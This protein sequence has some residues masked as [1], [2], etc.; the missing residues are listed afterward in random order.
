MLAEARRT[1]DQ[2]DVYEAVVAKEGPMVTT[3]AGTRVH[4]AEVEVRLL[5]AGLLR[6]P[7]RIT[8]SDTGARL[9]N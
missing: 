4:P 9:S 3:K 6:L 1:L 2:I 5:R 7:D 8:L